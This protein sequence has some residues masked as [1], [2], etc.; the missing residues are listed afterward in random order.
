MLFLHNSNCMTAKLRSKD[1]MICLNHFSPKNCQISS[2]VYIFIQN[3][4]KPTLFLIKSNVKK[5]A[6]I[7]PALHASIFCVPLYVADFIRG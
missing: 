5:G 6:K 2:H 1:E 3:L 7:V 4:S